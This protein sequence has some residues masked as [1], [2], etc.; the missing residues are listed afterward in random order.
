MRLLVVGGGEG[1]HLRD[2]GVCFGWEG[3]AGWGGLT[4]LQRFSSSPLQ[5]A[6]LAN[7]PWDGTPHRTTEYWACPD[8]ATFKHLART[9]ASSHRT[10][11]SSQV[12]EDGA[13]GDGGRGAEEGGELWQDCC[14]GPGASR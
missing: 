9:Y 12:Q 2:R 14:T 8:D 10:M 4:W 3:H 6:V 1:P 7:Y 5:G 11:G 13:E